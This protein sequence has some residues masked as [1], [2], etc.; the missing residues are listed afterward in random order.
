VLVEA[1][2]GGL[3][4]LFDEVPEVGSQFEVDGS[5]VDAHGSSKW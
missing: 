5:E 1:T 4:V 2:E 3:D